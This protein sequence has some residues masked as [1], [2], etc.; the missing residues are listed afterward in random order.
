[1]TQKA[2]SGE[3][4]RNIALGG[5]SGSGKTMIAEYLVSQFG[6]TH[7]NTGHVVR[8]ICRLLFESESK[9]TLNRVSDA[10]RGI[11]ENVWLRAALKDQSPPIV[12]DSVRSKSEYFYLK[13]RGFHIWRVESSLQVRINRMRLRGQEFDP[14]NDERHLTEIDLD[15][16][17]FDHRIINSDENLSAL[18]LKVDEAMLLLS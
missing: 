4:Y 18:Y 1:M 15:D 6:Y 9:S 14:I 11:D 3:S 5:R 10:I 2:S 17:P 13:D 7:C 12:F 16:A 8:H